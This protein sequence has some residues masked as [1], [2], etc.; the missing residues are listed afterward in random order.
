MVEGI[1]AIKKMSSDK[2]VDHELRKLRLHSSLGIIADL[3]GH[4][5]EKLWPIFEKLEDE[6]LRLEQKEKRLSRYSNY[7]RL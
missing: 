4:G 6:L 2:A 5:N 7:Q 1:Q 3:I